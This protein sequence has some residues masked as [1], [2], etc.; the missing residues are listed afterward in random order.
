MLQ[1][2]KLPSRSEKIIPVEFPLW[3]GTELIPGNKKEK[4]KHATAHKE[5]APEL[6][7]RGGKKDR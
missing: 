5:D 4:G 3:G 1:E 7:S 2:S 6:E